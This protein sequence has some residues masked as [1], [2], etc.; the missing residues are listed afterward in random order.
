MKWLWMGLVV[1]VFVAMLWQYMGD[2]D[3][4]LVQVEKPVLISNGIKAAGFEKGGNWLNSEPLVLEDLLADESVKAVLVDFWTYSCINCQ[5]T[6]PYLVSWWEK[7]EDKGLVIVGVH[8]PE[9]E[10]EK[11]TA[12]VAAANEKYGVAWPVVQDNDYGIWSDYKNQY[13][14]RKYLI[15]KEGR[16]VY[17]HIGEGKYEETE[18]A[19]QA[20][21][22]TEMELTAEE[23]KVPRPMGGLTH[24]LYANRRGQSSGQIG[25][26]K[27]QIN[28][29]GDWE[30]TTDYA[31]AGAGASLKLDFQ[32]GEVNLVMSSGESTKKVGLLVD[33]QSLEDVLVR[34]S[35]LYSLWAGEYGRH[36]LEM[37]F[38][39]GTRIH[40]FTFGR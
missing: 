9:F 26:G 20:L 19:I 39:E 22:G 24:E 27:D 8:T 17:D 36:S 25:Q 5:R 40:A 30:I 4:S 21:L 37:T 31:Q 16:I 11:V 38:E 23:E 13:W 10:F 18:A 2:K 12:N 15:N 3:M 32:A 14:P 33:G 29:V 6:M 1:L 35:D 34:E 7:Y 28:L